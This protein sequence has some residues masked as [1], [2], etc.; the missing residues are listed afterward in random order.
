MSGIHLVTGGAGF[1][2]SHLVN[3][4]LSQGKKVRI[5]DNFSTGHMRNVTIPR[6]DIWNVD[7]RFVTS[8][9]LRGVSHIY[10][11]AA[12]GSVERSVLFPKTTEDVNVIGTINL[13]EAARIT[14]VER[15]V[16]ASSSSV[17]G[18]SPLFPRSESD[19]VSPASP[20]ALSKLSGEAYCD[21]YHLMHGLPTVCLRYFNVFGPRQRIEGEYCAV[22]P[23]F[24][25]AILN[26]AQPIIDG[27]GVQCRD[28]TYVDT[29]VRATI[30]A[31]EEPD[32]IGETINV[33]SGFEISIA[34]VL[35]CIGKILGIVI[36]PGYSPRRKGDVPRSLADVSLMREILEVEPV[37]FMRGLEETIKYY[38]EVQ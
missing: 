30:R 24:L 26:G 27:V 34:E 33:A 28:F 29:V 2:G 32:A 5:I 38:Q 19:S 22:I 31:G 4:L 1:I 15:F 12:L 23:R 6:G 7:I 11:L 20:Y 13:L 36:H 18:N 3:R 35:G 37:A 14:G 21:L 10:H 8:E 9:D 17:Y 16:F 25:K